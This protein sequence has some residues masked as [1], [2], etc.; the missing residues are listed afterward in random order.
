MKYTIVYVRDVEKKSIVLILWDVLPLLMQDLHKFANKLIPIRHSTG[1]WLSHRVVHRL[2]TLMGQGHQR[3]YVLLLY[4]YHSVHTLGGIQSN[5]IKRTDEIHTRP[6][7]F[8]GEGEEDSSHPSVL[9][10]FI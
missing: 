7:T 9:L 4:G 2:Y 1:W 8:A 10:V 3:T 5:I 6:F